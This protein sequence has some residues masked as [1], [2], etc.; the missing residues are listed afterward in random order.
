MP[1]RG[2][3]EAIDTSA[4]VSINGDTMEGTLNM[5]SNRVVNL[6]EPVN[7]SDA[8]TKVYVDTLVNQARAFCVKNNP[9]LFTH[10]TGLLN[11]NIATVNLVII[12]PE[13]HMEPHLTVE[14]LIINLSAS[15]R[16]YNTSP[17]IVGDPT[18][19]PKPVS[20]YVQVKS[21]IAERFIDRNRV[22]LKVHLSRD[23]RPDVDPIVMGITLINGTIFI[24]PDG[25]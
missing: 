10:K 12:L 16:F 7:T 1:F 17:V 20:A 22:L 3:E 15:S 24:L 13:T 2:Q 9:V 21:T 4:F 5:N 19:G 25:L 11:T 23:F 6:G 8:V 14:R 18:S